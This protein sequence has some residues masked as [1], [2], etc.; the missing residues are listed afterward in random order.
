MGADVMDADVVDRYMTE[1]GSRLQ[2]SKKQVRELLTETRDS[3]ADATEAHVDR[4]L[5]EREAQERAVEEFGPVREIANE[6]QA[7]LAVAY[8]TRT[9]VWLA[10]VLPLMHMAW[11]YGRMLL[12]GPWQD[13]GTRPPAWYLF[14]AQANDLTSGIA[15]GVA[16]VALVL[17]RVLARKYDT[18]LLA[19]AGA[20]IALVAVA[21]VLLGNLAIIL[22]T[23]HV[24]AS[25]LVQSLPMTIASLVTWIVI[26]RLGLLARRCLSCATIVA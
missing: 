4:G 22:A 12:I 25:R 6:Y 13:F 23:A 26:V 11:E 16:L 8:G 3:L 21:A 18:K 17:G 20:T 14:V 19:K 15:S 7:E 9:L 10:I 24:D 1:L 5:T 2:G